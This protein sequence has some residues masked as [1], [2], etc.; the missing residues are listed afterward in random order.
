M[1]QLEGELIAMGSPARN[2]VH[3]SRTG[4]ARREAASDSRFHAVDLKKIEFPVPSKE[5]LARAFNLSPA[6]IRLAQ[7]LARGESL[8]KIA[9]RVGVKIS[10]ARSQLAKIFSKTGVK[11]QPKL[12]ALLSRLAHLGH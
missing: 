4:A 7:H 10:T 2:S 8:E 12:V 1:D 6:E 9:P 3:E 5:L 11:R